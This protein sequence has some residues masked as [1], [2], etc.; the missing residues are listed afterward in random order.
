MLHEEDRT[1]TMRADDL[2]SDRHWALLEERGVYLGLRSMLIAYRL[3]GRPFFSLLLYPVIAYFFLANGA[4]RRASHDFLSR[5]AADRQGRQAVGGGPTWRHAY[6]HFVR[7]GEAALDKL[8]AWTGGIGVQD[9]DLENEESFEALRRSG[10]GGLLIASHLGNVEVCR[11]IGTH[12]KG[13]RINVLV[14]TKHAENFNRL[15]REECPESPV[16]LVQTTEIGPDTA[17]MLRERVERGEF[18][19]IAGD[20]VPVAGGAW[21][22]WASFLG[23]PAPFPGGPFIL[24]ALLGCPVLL[25]FC[26]REGRR[27][28]V[29]FEPF[30]DKIDMP[31]K[32][33]SKVVGQLVTRYAGRLEHYCLKYPYQWFNFFDFW[34]QAP[35]QDHDD[36]NEQTADLRRHAS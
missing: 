14:H 17:M 27:Y 8:L 13:L 10:S 12:A 6:R 35:R 34:G 1:V 18:V 28:R 19:V 4:A 23:K 2:R 32:S 33:R 25:L 36:S 11:A 5:V 31:R 9:L 24:A 29:I 22:A 7:F 15:M 20:R 26:I 16:L 30:A 21:I 3:L